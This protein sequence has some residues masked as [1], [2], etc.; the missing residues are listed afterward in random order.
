MSPDFDGLCLRGSSTR[1]LAWSKD[2]A[3]FLSITG[4]TAVTLF[5]GGGS[6]FGLRRDLEK[7]RE[8]RQND[9]AN[10]KEQ[11]RLDVERALAEG[12]AQVTQSMLVYGKS[13]LELQHSEK[14]K[15]APWR[16]SASKNAKDAKDA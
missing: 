3:Q 15:E 12:R 4:V 8:L 11:R 1:F 13:V 14:Y 2:N 7:E 10:E 5:L 9:V 16:Q 6:F